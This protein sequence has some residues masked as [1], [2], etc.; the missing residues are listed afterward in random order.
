LAAA[1][2]REA[3]RVSGWFARQLGGID[4]LNVQPRKK[5]SRWRFHK[6]V[7]EKKRRCSDLSALRAQARPA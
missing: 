5:F 6:A 1:I 3:L 2:P 7:L 4:E